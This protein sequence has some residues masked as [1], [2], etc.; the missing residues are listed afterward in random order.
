MSLLPKTILANISFNY[1]DTSNETT[2]L[3]LFVLICSYYKKEIIPT[4]IRKNEN[5]FAKY[6]TAENEQ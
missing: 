5:T 4:E 2:E 6:L 1:F 3:L